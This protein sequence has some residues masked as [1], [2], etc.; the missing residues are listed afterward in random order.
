MSSDTCCPCA[1]E[2]D[3]Q[4]AHIIKK[5]RT[6]ICGCGGWV[7]NYL[8][9][10]EYSSAQPCVSIST[11]S[12]ATFPG[13]SWAPAPS[14]LGRLHCAAYTLSEKEEIGSFELFHTASHVPFAAKMWECRPFSLCLFRLF[15]QYGSLCD[16][17]RLII[18]W[19]S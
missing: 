10:H 13:G 3:K 6:R 19:S 14:G 9:L 18:S 8:P 7:L 4:I 12:P 2:Q 5:D 11:V 15:S 16:L 17:S 1:R